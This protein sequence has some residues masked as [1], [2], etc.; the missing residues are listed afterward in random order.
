MRESSG[1]PGRSSAASPPI[2]GYASIDPR[3]IADLRRWDDGE[4]AFRGVALY[5]LGESR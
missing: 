2:Y 1:A 3:F 4:I 5:D